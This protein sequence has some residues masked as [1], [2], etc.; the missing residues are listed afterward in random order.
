MKEPYI[1][2]YLLGHGW[3]VIYI[4]TVDSLPKRVKWGGKADNLTESGPPG[5]GLNV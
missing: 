2:P 4:G 5:L 3:M 1:Y